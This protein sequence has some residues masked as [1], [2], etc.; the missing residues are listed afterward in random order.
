LATSPSTAPSTSWSSGALTSP[1]AVTAGST[2]YINSISSNTTTLTV[3]A[4][5]SGTVFMPASPNVTVSSVAG[6]QFNTVA[7]STSGTQPSDTGLTYDIRVGT[8]ANAFDLFRNASYAPGNPSAFSS[9]LLL[10]QLSANLALTG[11][12]TVIANAGS[13]ASTSSSA[14][15][16]LIGYPLNISLL[17]RAYVNGDAQYAPNPRGNFIYINNNDLSGIFG[18]SVNVYSNTVIALSNFQGGRNTIIIVNAEYDTNGAITYSSNITPTNT[19]THY[20]G[21]GAGSSITVYYQPTSFLYYAMSFT[22][23]ALSP[24][25]AVP[26]GALLTIISTTN[27]YGTWTA[28][29]TGVMPTSYQWTIRRAFFP[30]TTAATGTVSYSSTSTGT[31][32]NALV[33]GVSYVLQVAGYCLG[34]TAGSNTTGSVICP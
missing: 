1:I 5:T 22:A 32:T 33:S 24:A 3:S 4:I 25:A 21:I 31:Q 29:T 17:Y 28:P 15:T 20:Y 2:Y 16:T 9:N 11:Y 30:P 7:I 26:T 6:G 13:Y 27:Y 14:T 18:A 34:L 8:S 19:S 12:I 10:S 23:T